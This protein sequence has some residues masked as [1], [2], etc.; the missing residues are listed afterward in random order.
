MTRKKAPDM[1][2]T[3]DAEGTIRMHYLRDNI[4]GIYY[5]NRHI[6]QDVSLDGIKKAEL[7]RASPAATLK[8]MVYARYLFLEI[9]QS[10][11]LVD[12]I[13]EIMK[14]S[15]VEKYPRLAGLIEQDP[16][17][18]ELVEKMRQRLSTHPSFTLREAIDEIEPIGFERFWLHAQRILMFK[19]AVSVVTYT[20]GSMEGDIKNAGNASV[21]PAKSLTWKEKHRL[22]KR[23]ERPAYDV[24]WGKGET[25][26][27]LQEC[28]ACLRALMDEHVVSTALH[29]CYKTQKTLERLVSSTYNLKDVSLEV[30]EFMRVYKTLG[31]PHSPESPTEPEF[32]ARKKK[33]CR[34]RNKYAAHDDK[35]VPSIMLIFEDSSF[36]SELARDVEEIIILARRLC[37]DYKPD[38]EI[39]LPTH[40]KTYEMDAEIDDLGRQSHEWL[41]GKFQDSEYMKKCDELRAA[42]A[43]AYGLK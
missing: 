25:R 21:L 37:G 20:P 12:P 42:V 13:D 8:V 14:R 19:D 6:G 11:I 29:R 41:E 3:L 23:Y 40:E 5:T 10:G 35:H 31:I 9:W 32:F 26:R 38:A 33:Y 4:R 28:V 22:K 7:G 27:L 24:D 16:K 39:P 18:A 1:E 17:T 43:A 30:Y 34:Y 2:N 36:V 15:G